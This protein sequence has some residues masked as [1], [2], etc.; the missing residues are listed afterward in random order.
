M[1]IFYS[2]ACSIQFDKYVVI[3]GGLNTKNVSIYFENGYAGNIFSLNSIR[4]SHACGYFF[5]N[6]LDLVRD[7]PTL[8]PPKNDDKLIRNGGRNAILDNH[9]NEKR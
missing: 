3:T 1:I 6:E 2:H 8:L 7:P 5:N 4:H 9:K